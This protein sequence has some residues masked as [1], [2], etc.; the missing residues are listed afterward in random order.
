MVRAT[1]SASAIAFVLLVAATAP[2]AGQ[3]GDGP[4][5]LA[6]GFGSV[7]IGMG[8]GDIV[9]LDARTG[10]QQ[11]RFRAG[12]RA[13]VHELTVAYGAVWGVRGQVVRIDPRRN[14]S[15]DVLGVGSATLFTISRGAG[16]LW[17]ADDGSN[18]ILRIDP[19]R[20]RLAARIKVPG[21]AWGVS[22]EGGHVVVVSVPRAGPV[23][24]PVGPRVLH[25]IDPRTNRLSAP[26]ARI[27]CDVGVTS[28]A[29]AVWTYDFCSGVLAR[30]DQRTLR[31]SRQA[32]LGVLSQKPAVAF[33]SVW[34]ASRGGVLRVDPVTLRV[35]ARIPARSL[36]VAIGDGYVWAFDPAH[37]RTR[38]I[39]P[40]T[41]R[42]VR[43]FEVGPQR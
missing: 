1:V 36:T 15:R 13:F 34:L 16:A 5:S 28:G 39:N 12:A 14:S 35:V 18:E 8:D 29:G 32:K 31:V 17:L 20:E 6:V 42:V 26:L 10:E 4:T 33:G 7:W 2:G 40:R 24:G 19:R 27:G 9:R 21:R 25:R 23:N 3:K 41:N 11:A 38:T 30:R 22:A 37:A 43:V